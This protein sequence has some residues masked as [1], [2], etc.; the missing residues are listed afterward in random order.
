MTFYDEVGGHDTF[1]KI[2]SV[3]YREVALDP[4]LKPMYPEEDL[5]PAEERLLMFLEQYWG[6]LLYTSDAADE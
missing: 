4:V 3:F 2:V 5:G 6:C 1:A